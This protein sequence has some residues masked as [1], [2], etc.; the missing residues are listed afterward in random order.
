MNRNG[1]QEAAERHHFG[2]CCAFCASCVLFLFLPACEPLSN[3]PAD[4][5]VMRESRPVGSA[6]DFVVDL[7]YDV[8]QLEITKTSDENLFSFDLQYDKRRYDPKFTFSGGDHASLRLEM[9]AQAGSNPGRGRDNVLTLR[10]SDKVTLNLNVTTGVSDSNLEMTGLRLRRMH[11][12]GGVGKTE[13]AFDKPS[14]QVLESFEAESG[15]GELV[16]HGLGNT[17]VSHLDLKGG[18]GRAELDF[19]GELGMA[20]SDATIQVGVGEIRLVIPRQADVEIEGEGSFLSNVSAP[21]FDHQGHNY[22][23]HGEGGAKIYIRVKSGIGGIN[24]EL[25]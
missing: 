18:V 22:T 9:N 7:K 14:G 13:V 24:V 25:I 5:Q 15:V 23:H 8:G 17:Q 20:R 16:V 1:T 12:R 21:S 11:L 4:V 2:S 19:T 6:M 10:L 3:E